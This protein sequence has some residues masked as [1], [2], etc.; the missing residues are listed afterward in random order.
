MLMR[1]KDTRQGSK[2]KILFTPGPLTTSQTVKQ[3]QL[4]DLGSRDFEFITI[5]K[6]IREKLIELGQCVRR[7]TKWHKMV[8]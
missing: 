4:R 3:A 8:I 5:V 1:T 6:Q 7:L 2:D